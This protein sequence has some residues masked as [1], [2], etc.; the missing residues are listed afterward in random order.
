MNFFDDEEIAVKVNAVIYVGRDQK[1]QMT[2][3]KEN[4]VYASLPCKIFFHLLKCNIT[5]SNE[6]KGK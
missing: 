3:R 4:V 5:F 2:E 1:N 6:K